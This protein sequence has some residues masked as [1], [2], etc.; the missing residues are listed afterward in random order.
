MKITYNQLCLIG[1]HSIQRV[2]LMTYNAKQKNQTTLN[3]IRFVYL[4]MFGFSPAKTTNKQSKNPNKKGFVHDATVI[5]VA[6]PTTK[7]LISS[8]W[9]PAG[10]RRAR[11][12]DRLRNQR[13]PK[14]ARWP[15]FVKFA[16][17]DT[18]RMSSGERTLRFGRKN[19]LWDTRLRFGTQHTL[20][21]IFYAFFF[22]VVVRLAFTESVRG[23]LGPAESV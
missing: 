10:K 18:A 3:R 9:A 7:H 22:F 19:C 12:L 2:K 14:D 21:A 13:R 11:S 1:I 5:A 15:R 20:K 23:S 6:C 8:S 4:H 17:K 16:L